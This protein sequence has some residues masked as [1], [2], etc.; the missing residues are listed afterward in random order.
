LQCNEKDEAD[1]RP[2]RCKY[3]YRGTGKFTSSGECERIPYTG[4]GCGPSVGTAMAASGAAVSPNWGYHTSPAVAAL[5]AIF[6]VRIGWWTGN[7]R[8]KDS[9]NRYA[10]GAYYLT[11]ELQ[12]STNDS[13]EYVYLSDGG[14]FENLGIYELVRRR[15]K[16][17][18]A[19]DAG[20]DPGYTFEDLANA[21]EK[22]RRD[23]GVELEIDAS[24]IRPNKKTQLSKSHFAVGKIIYP[25]TPGGDG[26]TGV[27]VFFKSSL[28]GDESADILG[29]RGVDNRFPHDTTANQFFN[30][31]QFEVYRALGEHMFETL[32]EYHKDDET[33]PSF[34]VVEGEP[35]QSLF[36]F[37]KKLDDDREQKHKQMKTKQ[38][39]ALRP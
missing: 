7:P 4:H 36:D 2:N 6:N 1:N 15:M 20:S 31:T 24:A 9:W 3:G 16:Y 17:I 22:C 8:R 37:F 25:T 27:L 21:V 39:Q 35:E 30:E 14:H 34:V 13:G 33:K 26:F 28:T 11:A 38:Q 12:G 23:F 5:L 19:C 32:R 18:I 10:P 29:Q